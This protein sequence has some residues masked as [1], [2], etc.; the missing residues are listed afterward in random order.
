MGL[1]GITYL[2]IFLLFLS[3]YQADPTQYYE[4]IDSIATEALSDVSPDISGEFSKTPTLVKAVDLI[5]KSVILSLM[6]TIY[7]IGFLAEIIPYSAVDLL[8]LW[9][10]L[11]IITI[12][13]WNFVLGVTFLV[14]DWWKKRKHKKM[15]GKIKCYT[16]YS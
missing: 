10:V 7:M 2:G 11:F 1:N 5:I 6:A 15:G 8:N 9:A 13:P 16:H 14:K 12:I 4:R 3:F